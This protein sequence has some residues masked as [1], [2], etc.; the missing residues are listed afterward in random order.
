MV[1]PNFISLTL[2]PALPSGWEGAGIPD[3]VLIQLSKYMTKNNIELR[4]PYEVI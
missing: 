4:K 3:R 1:N 2:S